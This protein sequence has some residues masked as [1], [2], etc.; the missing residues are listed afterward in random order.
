[1][2]F[3]ETPFKGLYEIQLE[4][5]GDNRG[6][7]MRTFDLAVFKNNILGF[8]SVWKQMNHSFNSLKYTWRGFHFQEAPY[9]ETKVVRCI[10]GSVLDC[11]L[12]LRE[13]SE[14]Y[15]KTFQLELS[16]ENS[17]MLF[18]PKGFAHGF[19]TLEDNVELVYLHDEYYKPE[20][21]KGIRFNDPKISFDLPYT[22]VVISERDNKHLNIN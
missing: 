4:S 22:P 8:D 18:I 2:I 1:M 7:F 14:T 17:K 21:E 10:S 12:D 15:L 3:L 9:Q 16:K 13:N 6:S 20:F 5:K 11:V 19:L